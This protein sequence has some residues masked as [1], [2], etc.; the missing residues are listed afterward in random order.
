MSLRSCARLSLML[1]VSL[2]FPL[3]AIRAQSAYDLPQSQGGGPEG[4]AKSVGSPYVELD[5]WIY[6]A[7]ERL[8]ALGYIDKEFLGMRPWTRIEC[9]LLVEEAGDN[10]RTKQSDFPEANDL[11]DA[12][13]KNFSRIS[14]QREK[15]D[16]PSTWSRFTQAGRKSPVD[17]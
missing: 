14:T 3:H 12:L 17:H 2:A 11:Y 8:A 9:A 5:S 16:E 15:G 10:A 4:N 6:P 7:L 13:M 1:I